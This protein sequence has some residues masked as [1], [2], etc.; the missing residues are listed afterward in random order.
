MLHHHENQS[1][2]LGYQGWDAILMIIL[3]S[4]Q[5]SPTPNISAASVQFE[6]NQRIQVQ[7][8][9]K[10]QLKREAFLE[11]KCKFPRNYKRD[12]Q[13]AWGKFGSHVNWFRKLAFTF[14]FKWKNFFI[15]EIFF[16]KLLSEFS[17][18]LKALVICMYNVHTLHSDPKVDHYSNPSHNWKLRIATSFK[19]G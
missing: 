14:S 8:F 9:I 1:K 13:T 4:S 6:I 16:N 12:A 18:I 7:F 10:W 19:F 11:N 17:I 15:S 3:V 2:V 5:K